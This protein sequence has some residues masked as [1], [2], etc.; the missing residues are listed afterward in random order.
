LERRADLA[1]ARLKAC[2]ERAAR[3]EARVAELE[4]EA[5]ET[6]D[7]EPPLERAVERTQRNR[8]VQVVESDQL[9]EAFKEAIARYIEANPRSAGPLRTVE[10]MAEQIHHGQVVK[11]RVGAQF[12]RDA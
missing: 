3:A 4:G 6:I 10:S 7:P 8:Y 1:L 9:G 2:Q 11:D 12:E 5:S